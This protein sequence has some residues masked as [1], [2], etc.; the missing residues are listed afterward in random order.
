[1]PIKPGQH[2]VD[3]LH[4]RR[5]GRSSGRRS[6]AASSASPA[7]AL[8]AFCG[9]ESARSTTVPSSRRSKGLGRYSKAPRSV[10]LTAVRSVFCALMTMIRSPGR[11]FLILRNQVETVAVR[12]HHIGDHE[13]AVA[14][15]DPLP[16]GRGR[17]GAAHPIALPALKRAQQDGPDGPVIVGDEYGGLAHAARTVAAGSIIL[18]KV[19]LIWFSNSTRPPWSPTTLA[20]RPGPG[21]A[22]RSWSRRRDRRGGPEGPPAHPDRCR[23]RQ[24][25]KGS[26]TRLPDPGRV[27]RR[28]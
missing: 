7:I 26:S 16:E 13:V 2:A 9:S 20:T 21:R 18:N 15:R 27:R 5:T 8:R 14:V 12:Q 17:P 24:P 25:I 6:S 10:A 23:G 1:M 28:P 4:G 11:S 3:L 22:R 19:P